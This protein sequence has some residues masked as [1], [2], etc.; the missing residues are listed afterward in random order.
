MVEVQDEQEVRRHARSHLRFGWWSLLV[1]LTTGIALEGLHGL[2]VGFYLDVQ[3]ETRRLMWTLGHAHGTLLA[4]V[5]LAFA[6]ATRSIWSRTTAGLGVASRCLRAGAILLPSGFFLGGA[7]IYGGDP[8]LGI[9]LVPL[10]AA[11]VLAA[12]FVTAMRATRDSE[13]G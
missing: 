6:A 3:N 7:S 1:F 12:V 4:L 11:L 2:K 5:N 9:L 8:G 13:P 10:G